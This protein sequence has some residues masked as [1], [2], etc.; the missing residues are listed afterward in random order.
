ME[1]LLKWYHA[2]SGQ[3]IIIVNPSV[4]GFE[5]MILRLNVTATGMN[6]CG[7]W[8]I[9][10]DTVPLLFGCSWHKGLLFMIVGL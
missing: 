6:V 2:L 5:G 7:T 1:G 3:I 10:G 8:D 4:S 9:D